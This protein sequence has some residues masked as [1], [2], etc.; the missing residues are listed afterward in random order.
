MLSGGV[1]SNNDHPNFQSAQLRLIETH[2]Y[3]TSNEQDAA[4]AQKIQFITAEEDKF[5]GMWTD[6][7]ASNSG[8]DKELAFSEDDS[9]DLIEI[10]MPVPVSNDEPA[11]TWFYDSVGDDFHYNSQIGA[12]QP[13]VLDDLF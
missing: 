5:D 7:G 12:S 6:D 4:D 2:V 10:D 3:Q 1:M 8:S 9:D 11:Q 13:R